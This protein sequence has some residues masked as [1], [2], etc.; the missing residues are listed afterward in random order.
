M[1]GLSYDA[2]II[3]FCSRSRRSST[4]VCV[5][6]QS[7]ASFRCC[8]FLMKNII[9]FYAFYEFTSSIN[10]GTFLVAKNAYHLQIYTCLVTKQVYL[11]M[12]YVKT[13]FSYKIKLFLT[14]LWQSSSKK[15]RFHRFT[16]D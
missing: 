4:S 2:S 8:T 14:T 13:A 12:D 7:L 6:I 16:K 15:I 11:N 5:C 10:F 3:R 1:N 9:L